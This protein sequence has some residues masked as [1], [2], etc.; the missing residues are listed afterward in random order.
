MHRTACIESIYVRIY[1]RQHLQMKYTFM[2][3]KTKFLQLIGDNKY[4]GVKIVEGI[5]TKMS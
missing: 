4:I 5:F 2:K 1:T 3:T